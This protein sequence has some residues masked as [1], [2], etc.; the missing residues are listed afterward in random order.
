MYWNGSGWVWMGL[1]MILF[2]GG[3]IVVGV[4]LLRGGGF[5]RKVESPGPPG[6]RPDATEILRARFARGEIT[7]DEYRR[8][9][10]VLNETK[11]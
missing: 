9:L 2:W 7:E 11:R 1:M 4:L 5:G 3:L 10:T 6:S 8:S